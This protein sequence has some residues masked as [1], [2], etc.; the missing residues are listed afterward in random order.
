MHSSSGLLISEERNRWP[1]S[2][3]ETARRGDRLCYDSQPRIRCCEDNREYEQTGVQ[4]ECAEGTGD[5]EAELGV[6]AGVSIRAVE[7]DHDGVP[8][9]A[10]QQRHGGARRMERR[11]VV[12]HVQH[13]D[14]V[15][16][17]KSPFSIFIRRNIS[18]ERAR[19]RRAHICIYK[20]GS[21]LC[22]FDSA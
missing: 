13:C 2:A 14:E 16:R 12:I 7:A 1:Q 6:E 5:E 8:G 9:H 18:R 22:P 10:L 15:I 19:E 11:R 20:P 21:C 3:S 4:V 17:R